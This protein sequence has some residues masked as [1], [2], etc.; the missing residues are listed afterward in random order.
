MVGG[1]KGNVILSQKCDGVVPKRGGILN[2]WSEYQL[3]RN[4]AVY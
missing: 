3:V 2:Q 1:G 4:G